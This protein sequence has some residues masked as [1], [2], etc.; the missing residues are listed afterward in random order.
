MKKTN[1]EDFKNF[2]LVRQNFLTTEK[3]A[4]KPINRSRE[5]YLAI[6][7]NRFAL[8]G[9]IIF[10]LLILLSL[11]FP[12]IWTDANLLKPEQQHYGFFKNGYIFGTDGQGRDFWAMLWHATRYSL[13]LAFVV[14]IVDLI[15]GVTLGLLMGYYR[16]VDKILQFIIK[17]LTNIPSIL[18]LIIVATALQPTFWT[19]ALGLTLTGWINMSLQ[20][21][22]QV[23][24]N[25][26]LDY[27]VASK[28]L[29]TPWYQ[30]LINFI[31]VALPIIITGLVAT[32][33]IAIISEASLGFIGLSVPD[34]ITLGNM[35]NKARLTALVY[36]RQIIVPVITLMVITIAIQLIGNGI[37]DIIRKSQ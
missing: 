14:V 8:A 10:G 20:V 21:R 26:Q 12:L 18:I 28:I 33:P 23:L 11:I 15:V 34:A 9:I 32:I 16:K 25:K 27:F 3:L 4:T 37:Q 29:G 24:K 30:Q 31:P 6:I 7:A 36:P 17:I 35:I 5:F 19:M 2:K 13:G 22:A 1:S